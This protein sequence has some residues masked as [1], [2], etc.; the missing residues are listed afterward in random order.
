MM[1]GSKL[2]SNGFV[3]SP[4]DLQNTDGDDN[5]QFGTD[6][7][8]LYATVLKEWRCKDEALVDEILLNRGYEA[9]DLGF[10]YSDLSNSNLRNPDSFFHLATYQNQVTPL[11]FTPP[12]PAKLN[13]ELFNIIGQK[14]GNIN[15]YFLLTVPHKIDVKQAIQRR[16]FTGQ[17]IYRI[18]YGGTLYSKLILVK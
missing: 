14:V 2:D 17:Y 6:Y 16:L 11:E 15:D 3:G 5:L 18:N 8:S 12:S 4:P 10:N 9:L 7:R 13:I 1:F